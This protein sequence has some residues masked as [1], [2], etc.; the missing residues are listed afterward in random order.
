M[1]RWGG[2]GRANS[3]T[4]ETELKPKFK[5]SYQEFWL[6]K[7][8]YDLYPAL[9]TTVI[10]LHLAFL[11]SYLVECGFSIVVQLAQNKEIPFRFAN[12]VI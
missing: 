7:E 2:G 1:K 12:K 6:Q 3:A 4:N 10:K 8:I 5:K 9:R 11:T